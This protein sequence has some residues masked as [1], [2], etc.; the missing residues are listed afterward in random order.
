MVPKFLFPVAFCTCLISGSLNA[1]LPDLNPIPRDFTCEG[2]LII[3][4]FDEKST[5]YGYEQAVKKKFKDYKGKYVL[6]TREE[7]KTDSLYQDKKTYRFFLRVRLDQVFEV[8][9]DKQR[10]AGKMRTFYFVDRE[11]GEM[12]NTF[13]EMRAPN[14]TIENTVKTLNGI[15]K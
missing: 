10:Y 14:E 1:Q 3:E 6:A 11:T 13:R 9:H 2:T 15:C 12:Y 8:A 7:T 4:K 5:I